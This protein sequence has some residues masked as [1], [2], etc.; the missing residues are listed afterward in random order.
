MEQSMIVDREIRGR[1]VCSGKPAC[2]DVPYVVVREAVDSR[3]RRRHH[4]EVP[5]VV[6]RVS[7]QAG[8]SWGVDDLTKSIRNSLNAKNH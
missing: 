5:A 4:R 1:P 2:R 8:G 3:S 6:Q 7:A